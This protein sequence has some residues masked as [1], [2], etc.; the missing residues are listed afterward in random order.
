MPVQKEGISRAPLNSRPRGKLRVEQGQMATFFISWQADTHNIY[1]HVRY[2]P[3]KHPWAKGEMQSVLS[4][5][6]PPMQIA[7]QG[8]DA[9]KNHRRAVSRRDFAFVDL[10]LHLDPR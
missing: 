2:T 6:P 9:D 1:I 8:T 4:F 10:A 5:H 3:E 7:E